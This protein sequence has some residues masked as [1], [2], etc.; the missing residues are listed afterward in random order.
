MNKT[1]LEGLAK[2]YALKMRNAYGRNWKDVVAGRLADALT[3]ELV[4]IV[5]PIIEKQTT[6]GR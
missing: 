2:I 1:E 3:K 6:H 4:D 5:D